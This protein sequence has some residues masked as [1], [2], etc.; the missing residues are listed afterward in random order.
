MIYTAFLVADEV[1]RS[2]N[3]TPQ[4]PGRH[5]RRPYYRPWLGLLL[6]LTSLLLLTGCTDDEDVVRVDLTDVRIVETSSILNVLAS[7]VFEF[8]QREGGFLF[9][10]QNG[11]IEFGKL[12]KKDDGVLQVPFVIRDF[13]TLDEE[14]NF[15]AGEGDVDSEAACRFTVTQSTLPKMAADNVTA[16]DSCDLV[17]HARGIPLG[18]SGL[19]ELTWH[20]ARCRDAKDMSQFMSVPIEVTVAVDE[21]GNL[22]AVDG[23]PVQAEATP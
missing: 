7:K 4:Y 6:V 21:A 1:S 23:I 16:C 22:T 15:E 12:E 14:L 10:V 11:E 17:I 18:G 13:D 5:T 2:C 9:D 3:A 19:G 8:T 20:L